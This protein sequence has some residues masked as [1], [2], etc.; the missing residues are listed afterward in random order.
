MEELKL[1]GAILLLVLI[2]FAVEFA[3][4]RMLT[5]WFFR[6]RNARE[7]W[8]R[9]LIDGGPTP[10]DKVPLCRGKALPLEKF[11]RAG[12]IEIDPN[13]GAPVVHASG[14]ARALMCCR[15]G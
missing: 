11:R 12:L 9:G 2:L 4:P 1:I 15:S 14:Y 5:E 8:L 7:F 6:N 3:R 10:Y 13:G